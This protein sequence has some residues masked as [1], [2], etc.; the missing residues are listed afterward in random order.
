MFSYPYGIGLTVAPPRRRRVN[1]CLCG[2]KITTPQA[3]RYV[4]F[5]RVEVY[6]K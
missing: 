6:G 1:E 5:M 2:H 3:A 4:S